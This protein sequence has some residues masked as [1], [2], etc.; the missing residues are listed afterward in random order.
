MNNMVR[1]TGNAA[2]KYERFLGKKVRIYYQDMRGTNRSLIGT[3][4]DINGDVL[5]LENGVWQG[6]LNCANARICIVSTTEGWGQNEM[7][8]K[9][10]DDNMRY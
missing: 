7:E 2:A 1:N 4:T 6:S 9:E 10:L 3:I 8:I 5:E